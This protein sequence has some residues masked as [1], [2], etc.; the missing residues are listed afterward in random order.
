V[1][2]VVFASIIGVI[3]YQQFSGGEKAV[4]PGEALSAVPAPPKPV[5]PQAGKSLPTT[6]Q[7]DSDNASE[8]LNTVVASNK[9]LRAQV[10]KVLERNDALDAEVRRLRAGGGGPA[11]TNRAMAGQGGAGDVDMSLGSAGNGAAPA[12]APSASGVGATVAAPERKAPKSVFDKALETASQA[13]ETVM[14]DTGGSQR[15]GATASGVVGRKPVS[16]PAPNPRAS[17]DTSLGDGLTPG[18]GQVSYQTRAPLGFM[19]VEDNQGPRGM[20]Q[21]RYVRSIAADA[22]GAPAATAQAAAYQAA[23]QASQQA[24][25]DEAYFTVPENATMTGVVAMT[26]LIG[27]VPI[28]GRVTDPMQFKA[29]IGRD[30]LAANGWELPDDVEGMI[31]SGV[32]IGDMALSCSEGKIRSL[33]FVFHDGSIRT[34]STRKSAAGG[35]PGAGGSSSQGSGDLGYI[36]DAHGNPCIPGKFVTNAPAFLTDIAGLKTLGVAGQAYAEAQRTTMASGTGTTSTVNNGNKY[37]MGQ[38]VAGATDEV[39]AWMMQRLKNSFDAVV[40]PSG[41]EMVVHFDQEIRLD[42]PSNARKIIHRSQALASGQRG[43]HHGLE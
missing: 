37:A 25:A 19:A 43:A 15:T 22:A 29:M 31:V 6:R 11:P 34:V 32:A 40:I 3:L 16:T 30:N 9:E 24:K 18:A 2:G 35:A 38:A 8:T 17:A 23:Q 12:T 20:K 5:K 42:K 10:A 26:S 14:G 39:T 27:R 41:I 1:L 7:G 36:S 13:A 21:T 28:D 4:K 33:T